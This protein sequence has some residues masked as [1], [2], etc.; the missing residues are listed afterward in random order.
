MPRTGNDLQT[1]EPTSP[2]SSVSRQSWRAGV[3]CAVFISVLVIPAGLTYYFVVLG[4]PDTSSE[5]FTV[6]FLVMLPGLL[7]GG[8]GLLV[9]ALD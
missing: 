2:A 8:S 7:M 4:P 6:G 3:L 9:T 1:T 5:Q